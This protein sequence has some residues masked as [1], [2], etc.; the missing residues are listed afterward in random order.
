M[1]H[2]EKVHVFFGLMLAVVGGLALW[3]AYRP[4]SPTRFLWPIL[5]F[6]VGFVVFIPVEAQTRTYREVGWWS[7]ILSAVPES[8]RYW[9]QNWFRYLSEI[10]V[11]QHK[12]GG[13]LAMVAGVIEWYRIR[14]R[15]AAPGWGWALPALLVGIGLAFG[16]HG[17]SV[18]HLPFRVEQ[19][20]HRIFGGA[21]VLA[22]VLLGLI[23]G[24]RLRHAVWAGSWAAV[25]LAAGLS[26]TFFYR[27][28]P[29]ERA[30]GAE[31]THASA[32]PGMR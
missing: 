11:I 17:G 6:L 32:G 2:T 28:S 3:S 20:Q 16:I 14:G 31:M 8:P 23:R 29:A 25:L 21:I 9:A 24:G 10:H 30:M 27:L 15:L 13:L 5:A 19:V 4:A 7:T 1:T 12:V 18:E 22:G 26:I